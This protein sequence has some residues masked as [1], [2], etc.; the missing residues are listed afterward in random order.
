MSHNLATAAELDDELPL[1]ERRLPD[2]ILDATVSAT[3]SRNWSS[4]VGFESDSEVLASSEDECWDEYTML[5]GCEGVREVVVVLAFLFN[6]F[7]VLSVEAFCFLALGVFF[8]G[9]LPLTWFFCFLD[10]TGLLAES[11]G[12]DLLDSKEGCVSEDVF[13]ESCCEDI[14]ETR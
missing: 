7:E 8:L 6:G 3:S 2:V 12:R 1:V 11:C 4:L 9:A 14:T 10:G 5:F 13:T